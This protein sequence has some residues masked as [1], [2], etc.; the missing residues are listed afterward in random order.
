[1]TITF[2]RTGGSLKIFPH[3]VVQKFN[4]F[5]TSAG[6]SLRESF[7]RKKKPSNNSTIVEASAPIEDHDDSESLNAQV[8]TLPHRDSTDLQRRILL[9]HQAFVEYQKRNGIQ[10]IGTYQQPEI[11]ADSTPEVQR[12]QYHQPQVVSA[13]VIEEPQEISHKTFVNAPFYQT[14]SAPIT[15]TLAPSY[16]EAT[17]YSVKTLPTQRPEKVIAVVAS[18]SN[19]SSYVSSVRTPSKANSRSASKLS[20]ATPPP[21]NTQLD[22]SWTRH[23]S[24]SEESSV[25]IV[26][27]TKQTEY[28]QLPPPTP[29]MLEVDFVDGPESEL[30]SDSEKQKSQ[31]S[32]TLVDRL[33]PMLNA[34]TT[35]EKSLSSVYS[36]DSVLGQDRSNEIDEWVKVLDAQIRRIDLKQAEK[37]AL[38]A[39]IGELASEKRV[40]EDKIEE[41]EA[42]A[43]EER[44]VFEE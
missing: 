24:V 28:Q 31:K 12:V 36:N 20:Q 16:S 5:K 9:N 41:L 3:S 8:G 34:E 33:K 38:H 30:E 43:V 23:D 39:R 25:E 15:Q 13:E 7:S 6:T 26:D 19:R 37:D 21:T 11:R 18:K 35:T 29:E 17:T 1:M 42:R 44:D 32:V 14:K 40:L 4:Y 2:E 22:H 27:I 10:N